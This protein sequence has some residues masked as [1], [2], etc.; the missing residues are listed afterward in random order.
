M[1][2]N[3]TASSLM[4]GSC[5]NHHQRNANDHSVTISAN[6][7]ANTTITSLPSTGWLCVLEPSGRQV[8]RLDS[9][10]V[11]Q[12]NSEFGFQI[13]LLALCAFVRLI[14]GQHGGQNTSLMANM[15]SLTKYALG[16]CAG[17]I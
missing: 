6:G 7:S 8:A 12:F 3:N 1:D 17:G 9:L 2:T 5:E 13:K 15:I 16:C 11:V 4:N 14:A 10:N